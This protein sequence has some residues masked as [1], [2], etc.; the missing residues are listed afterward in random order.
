V[1]ATGSQRRQAQLRYYRPD[2]RMA[3]IRGN[4]ET[5]LRKLEDESLDGLILARAGL[6][7]LGLENT[8]TE[9]IDPEWL[10]P[11]V[12]QGALGVECRSDDEQSLEALRSLDHAPSRQAV[13]AERSLLAALGAGCQMPVGARTI[14]RDAD[15][16]LQA[17]VLDPDG[18]RRLAAEGTDQCDNADKLGC[19]VA[20]VLLNQGAEAC[21]QI[22]SRNVEH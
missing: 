22:P 7:R 12:G 14:I 21:L 3:S 20:Q 1:I 10:L 18:T 6:E 8:I 19:A 5:R 9:V 2:F 16:I 13:T 17:V 4:V 15:L 11:A